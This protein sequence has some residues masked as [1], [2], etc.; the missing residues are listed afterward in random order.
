[1]HTLHCARNMVKCQDCELMIGKEHED[2]HRLEFHSLRKCDQCEVSIEAFKLPEHKK[3]LCSKRKLICKFCHQPK[4]AMEMSDH[5]N[6]CGSRTERCD[7]CPD[8]VQLREWDSHQNRYHSNMQ[9][10]FRERSVIAQ[11]ETIIDYNASKIQ[12][13]ESHN[14]PMLPCEF[15]D[16]LVPMRKLL[17][18]QVRHGQKKP[19]SFETFHT[20][21]PLLCAKSTKALRKK[22]GKRKYFSAHTFIHF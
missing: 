18:H 5:E 1:M 14:D 6:Y 21:A 11:T 12:S 15:C 16:G 20:Q 8:W 2:A 7:R 22:V 10:R 17:E 4:M 19:D 9:R 13:E 3:T